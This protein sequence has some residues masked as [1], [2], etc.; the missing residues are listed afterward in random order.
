MGLSLVNYRPQ[1]PIFMKIRH[2]S[3]PNYL[4]A[5]TIS[6]EIYKIQTTFKGQEENLL[7]SLTV[8]VNVWDGQKYVW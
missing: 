6:I 8:Y 2:V 3:Y 7:A 5:G 1:Y 4:S